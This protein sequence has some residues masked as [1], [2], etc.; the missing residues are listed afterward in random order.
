M[1]KRIKSILI[2]FMLLAT[3]LFV[4]A[5]AKESG[6]YD[7][8]DAEGKTI[9]VRYDANGGTFA[10]NVQ[11][12]VDAYD[13]ENLPKDSDGNYLLALIDP[14]DSNRGDTDKH[15]PTKTG[16][17]LA[18]WYTE[19]TETGKDANGDPIYTY[20]NKWDFAN[21]TKTLDSSKEYTSSEPVLTLYAA[22]VPQFEINFYSMDGKEL[23]G[24]Y[25][26][27]PLEAT[28]RDLKVP[29]WNDEG[30]MAMYKFPKKDG[31]TFQAAY[32]DKEMT[33]ELTGT[34]VH[35]GTVD[36]AAGTATDT[37]MDVY[38]D[39]IKGNWY[40][41]Y[42]LEQF[43]KYAAPKN[44]LVLHTDLD[45]EG[46]NWNGSLSVGTFVGTIEGNGHTISNVTVTQNDNSRMTV[47]LFGVL[48]D[49]AQ[50]KDIHFENVTFVIQK[51]PR[52]AGTTYGLLAG[53][54][55]EKAVL[56]KVTI[57][58]SKVQVDAAN[59]FAMTDDYTIGLVCA[60]GYKGQVDY[61]GI[62]FEVINNDS[63]FV[64]QKLEIKKVEGEENIIE[65][66]PLED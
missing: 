54:I 65:V 21:N 40:H 66:S 18:G 37:S 36:E 59:F 12:I 3:L 32:Y 62:T 57:T 64:L 58:A 56:D 22:W 42:N 50:L 48:S 5:C 19:R 11:I 46:G 51:G 63:Q 33:K 9:S 30:A 31:Y 16:Y 27:N 4:T 15:M 39:F 49:E 41:V 23:I 8:L 13:T 25:K 52:T 10:T 17:F 7:G 35:T 38:V 55:K 6:H 2:P 34:I 60:E 47:G 14:N 1:K 20:A 43:R 24:T 44:S 29:E 53:A 45:F 28:E 26:Y 61:S